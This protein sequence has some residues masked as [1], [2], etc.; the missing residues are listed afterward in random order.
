MSQKFKIG[1]EVMFIGDKSRCWKQGE[2]HI[3]SSVE[4]TGECFEYA[5]NR[6]A[7]FEEDEFKLVSE[8]SKRTLKILTKLME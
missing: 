7:W 4:W 1:D 6:G 8:C 2:I 5:T 3:I